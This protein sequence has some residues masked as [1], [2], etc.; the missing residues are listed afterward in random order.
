MEETQPPVDVIDSLLLLPTHHDYLL[1]KKKIQI[2]RLY[3]YTIEKLLKIIGI[4]LKM[5]CSLSLFLYHDA[6]REWMD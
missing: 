1:L 3:D 5:C 2:L 4:F 6:L